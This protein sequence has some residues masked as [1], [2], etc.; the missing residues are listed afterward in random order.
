MGR[1]ENNVLIFEDTSRFIKESDKLMASIADTVRRQKLILEDEDIK[2][3]ISEKDKPANIVISS[4]RTLEAASRYKGKKV[5]I[6]NFASA[7]NPGGGVLNGSSAQEESICRCSTLYFALLSEKMFD[8]FYEPH[9]RKRDPLYNDDIIYSPDVYVVKSDTSS[10]ERLSESDWYSVN[11]ITCAAP[12]LRSKPSNQMNPNAGDKAADITNDDL[13]KLIEKRIRKIVAV[14]A[15]DNND[16]LIL[17]AFGCGAFRNPPKIV[18]KAFH[19]VLDEYQKYF[20][21]IEFAIYHTDYETENYNA[22][23]NEFH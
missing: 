9:R 23:I 22:F 20:E 3:S 12:N 10:P 7:T 15:A 4:K 2:L 18:A 1:R 14:A 5:C 8:S 16:V 19:K 13:E 11:V 6:L 21:T 17:G